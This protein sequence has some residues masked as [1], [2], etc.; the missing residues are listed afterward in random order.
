MNFNEKAE[1]P[2][3]SATETLI[4]VGEIF[5]ECEPLGVVIIHTDESGAVIVTGNTRKT[6]ALGMI[7]TAKHMILTGRV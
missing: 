3:R 1:K 4:A 5:G 7:E 2:Y 6:T